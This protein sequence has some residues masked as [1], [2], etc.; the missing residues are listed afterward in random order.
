MAIANLEGVVTR[1]EPRAE[2]SLF[3]VADEAA[4]AVDALAPVTVP[5]TTPPAA[6]P[7]LPDAKPA[8]APAAPAPAPA[9]KPAPAAD[10][11]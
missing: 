11:K 1:Y 8:P 5:V 3:D 2:R 6:V 10:A 7:A 9:A 4:K